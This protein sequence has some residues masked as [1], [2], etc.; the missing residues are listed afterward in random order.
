MLLYRPAVR[1]LVT[2]LV[3][4]DTLAV[5]AGE[6]PGATGRHLHLDRL[7]V[8]VDRAGLVLHQGD[9]ELL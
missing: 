2:S 7:G 1:Y 8:R 5:I 4:G 9:V 3:D 6:G